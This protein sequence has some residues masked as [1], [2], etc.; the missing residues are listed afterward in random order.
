MPNA[1]VLIVSVRRYNPY[2]FWGCLGVLQQREIPYILSSTHNYVWSERDRKEVINT[3]PLEA[4]DASLPFR[5]LM[6]V[7]GNPSDTRALWFDKQLK[8]L[9]VDSRSTPIAAICAAAPCVRYIAKGKRV[10]T[11]PLVEAKSLIK[12]SGGLLSTESIV[13]DPPIVTA[14]HQMRTVQWANAFCDLLQGQS[15]N[16]NIID[17]G[18]SPRGKPRRLPL[19]LRHRVE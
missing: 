17:S 11:Y 16:I 1:P 12:D 7:S 19:E 18:F 3:I 15:T 2:E 10:A 13:V 9:V 8:A 6:I 14:E 5:G 4:I